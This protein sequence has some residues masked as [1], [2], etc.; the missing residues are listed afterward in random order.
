MRPLVNLLL[1]FILLTACQS[2]K[3]IKPEDMPYLPFDIQD[4]VIGFGPVATSEDILTVHYTAYILGGD[5]VT[6]TRDSNSPLSITLGNETLIEGWETG[7][8]GMQKGGIRH[9]IVPPEM[10][11]GEEG[12][13]SDNIPPHATIIYDIELIVLDKSL[14]T[15]YQPYASQDIVVG[16]GSAAIAGNDLTV[17]YTAYILGGDTVANTKI[18]GSPLNIT[19]GIETLLDGWE[20]GLPGMQVGGIRRLTIPP[21]MAYGVVGFVPDNIPPHATIIYDIELIA[22]DQ[23]FM[24]EDLMI[25]TGAKV[26]SGASITVHYTGMLQDSTVFGTSVGGDPY[27]FTIGTGALITGWEEG[28]RS[29]KVGGTR[30]LTIPPEKGYGSQGAPPDIPGNAILIFEVELLG[31]Q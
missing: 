3:G 11:Y 15:L 13:D 17:H 5:T 9:L 18:S 30:R 21:E 29:M 1:S 27:V 4:T 26:F 12:F 7:L 25:G 16:V 31:I 6:N 2:D 20:T 28:L 23:S 22:L 14:N 10:A 24:I 19:L 8:Q